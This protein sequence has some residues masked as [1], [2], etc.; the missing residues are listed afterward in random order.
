MVVV[1]TGQPILRARVGSRFERAAS[2]CA[3][4]QG[5]SGYP[6]P[7]CVVP[8]AQLD[9]EDVMK[10]AGLVLAVG[11]LIALP[12]AAP[13]AAPRVPSSMSALGDSITRGFNAC[14]WFLDCPS[15]SW[16]TGSSGGV[17][18]HYLRIR[19][20][21]LR[22]WFHNYNDAKSGAEMAD[23]DGQARTAV[24][25]SVQYVT[26]LMGANDACSSTEAGMTAVATYRAQFE[27]A[28]QTLTTGLPGASIFVASVPDLK[29]LW[30]IGK[31]NSSARFAWTVFGICQSM[32]ADPLST[33]PADVARRERVRD[34]VIDY[35]ASLAGVCARYAACR[36]D[37]NA[38]FDYPFTLAQVSTWDYFHPSASGQAQ[39]A[40]ITYAAGF[41]W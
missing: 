6:C 4:H 17:S 31:A 5:G 8:R 12:S 16:S 35:N 19:A 36:F 7:V 37:G 22:L 23:L 10:R 27:Q 25:R 15:R 29:R 21:N 9:G 11:L 38:V 13:A 24:R 28:M 18:S 41:G 14:G 2:C 39:L 30:A 40:A 34:R 33:A 26:I 32:L 20:K 1:H 3:V